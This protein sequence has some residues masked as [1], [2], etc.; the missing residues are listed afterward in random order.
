MFNNDGCHRLEFSYHANGTNLGTFIVDY[1]VE[2]SEDQTFP[3][4]TFDGVSELAWKTV[5]LNVMSASRIRFTVRFC[6]RF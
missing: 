1:N 6:H 5:V 3:I 4:W 2:G